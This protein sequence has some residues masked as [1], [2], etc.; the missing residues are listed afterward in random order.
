MPSLFP[1]MLVALVAGMA[2]AVQSLFS[3]MIGSRVGAAE[4]SFIVHLGGFMLSG[5]VLLLIRGGAI[6][7]WHTVPWYALT[8]GFLGVVIVASVSFAVPRL[9]LAPTLTL[10]IVAQLL[11]GALLD[12]FGWLGASPR[13]LDVFRIIGLASVA[14]GTWLVVR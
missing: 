10:A 9:G 6:S 11:L 7:Q 8:A 14:G 4:S 12:H 3:G 5:V 2:I 1:A 13:P